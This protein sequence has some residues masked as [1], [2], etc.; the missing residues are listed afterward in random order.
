MVVHQ[1]ER[2]EVCTSL[3]ESDESTTCSP[4][5]AFC[6]NKVRTLSHGVVLS[7]DSTE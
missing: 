6:R 7:T 3:D 1:D 4:E 2:E 5:R